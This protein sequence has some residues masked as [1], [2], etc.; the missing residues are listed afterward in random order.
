MTT[1][2]RADARGRLCIRG[3][4]QGAEY[5]VKVEKQGWWVVPVEV[6]MPG[7]RNPR[8]WAGARVNL[9]EHMAAL[10]EGGLTL[11]QSANAQEAAGPCRF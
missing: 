6:E 2:V 8:K 3:T 7:T 5:L 4:Q 10:A 9:A 11:D 1:I